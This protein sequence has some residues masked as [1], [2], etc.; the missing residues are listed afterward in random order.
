[1]EEHPLT[2]QELLRLLTSAKTWKDVREDLDPEG[3]AILN[4]YYP[5]AESGAFEIVKRTIFP[6][7]HE[8]SIENLEINEEEA[9]PEL[10]KNDVHSVGFSA[11]HYYQ[12]HRESL[13]A[14]PV[15]N[16]RPNRDTIEGEVPAYPLTR[17]LYLYTGRD[18]YYGNALVRFFINY[19]L[20]YELDYL[21]DLGYFYPNKVK[22]LYNLAGNPIR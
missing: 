3:R 8:N 14:I 18:T 9:I 22:F 20:S 5:A 12:V 16:V 6:N 13:I 7:L 19:Y 15:R 1:L 21:D 2:S 10:V 17:Q 4:R 11:Y